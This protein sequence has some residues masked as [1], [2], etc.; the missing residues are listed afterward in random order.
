MDNDVPFSSFCNALLEIRHTV[1]NKMKTEALNKF[2]NNHGIEREKATNVREFLRSAENEEL[3]EFRSGVLRLRQKIARVLDLKVIDIIISD[4]GNNYK[5]L[6]ELIIPISER[7]SP[8][9]SFKLGEVNQKLK[10]LMGSK[11]AEES[12]LLRELF[13]NCI[14]GELL[15]IFAVMTKS[16]VT[17]LNWDIGC[18]RDAL[19]PRGNEEF[20][21]NRDMKRNKEEHSDT[22]PLMCNFEPMLLS[23]LDIDDWYKK[24]AAHSGINFFMEL[25]FDG[26]H[27]VI[28]KKGDCWR[29]VTRNGKDF[30]KYYD[31]TI[32]KK[33]LL[34]SIKPFL[35]STVDEVVV[36]CELMLYDE[37]AKKLV[38]HHQECADGKTYN[39]QHIEPNDPV[40]LVVVVLDLMYLNGHNFMG[41]P[42]DKRLQAMDSLLL[43]KQDPTVIYIPERKIGN[44]KEDVKAYFKEAMMNCDEGIVIKRRETLYEPGHRLLRNGWFKVKAN[45]TEGAHLDVAVV[46]VK[47][48]GTSREQQLVIAVK[49]LR[50]DKEELE[51]DTSFDLKVIGAVG[52]GLTQNERRWIIDE[53]TRMGNLLKSPPAGVFG[54]DIADG[55]YFRDWDDFQVVEVRCAGKQGG[56][57]QHAG[58]IRLRDDKDVKT[59]DSYLDFKR[60]EDKIKSGHLPELD[61]EAEMARTNRKRKVQVALSKT[62]IAS[63]GATVAKVVKHSNSLDGVVVSVIPGKN[64][65]RYKTLIEILKSFGAQVQLIPDEGTNFLVAEAKAVPQTTKRV[66]EA[67]WTVI[68]GVWVERC[69]QKKEIVEWEPSDVIY[70]KADGFNLNLRV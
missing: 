69:Q 10:Q 3:N 35:R 40:H 47:Y 13:E 37:V 20:K 38:R 11:D 64:D 17:S 12:K 21:R 33:N 48:E 19:N 8:Q 55:G 59:I 43:K 36:D 29:V 22:Y 26:E 24:I 50:F 49:R 62:K 42:F 46:G 45:L 18:L 65:K 4:S 27:V 34:E 16:I 58:M 1:N 2:I 51:E 70:G 14:A 30:T 60:L 44:S 31:G 39:Y 54:S 53:A 9:S 63:E 61:A 52:A 57:L 7:F 23:R 68:D 41:T 5:S 25:K 67:K 32:G 66:K 28:H 6:R 15:W 56:A